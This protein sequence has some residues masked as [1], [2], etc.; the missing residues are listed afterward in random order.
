MEPFL[1]Q[2]QSLRD[3]EA[4]APDPAAAIMQ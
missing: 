1:K 2:E 4:M 3:K